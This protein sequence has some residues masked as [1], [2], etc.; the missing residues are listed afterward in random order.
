MIQHCTTFKTVEILGVANT[1]E[2]EDEVECYLQDGRV[3]KSTMTQLNTWLNEDYD[4][5]R[6]TLV[7]PMTMS[8]KIEDNKTVAMQQ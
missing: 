1:E 3:V 6:L 2:T 8:I 4:L 7:L 5:E